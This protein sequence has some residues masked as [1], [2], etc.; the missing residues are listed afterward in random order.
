MIVVFAVYA[1]KGG[2]DYLVVSIAVVQCR[3]SVSE[4]VQSMSS[5][6][7]EGQIAVIGCRSTLLVNIDRA[8]H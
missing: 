2:Q 5:F 7:V 4:V 6:A 1:K 3:S 8:V